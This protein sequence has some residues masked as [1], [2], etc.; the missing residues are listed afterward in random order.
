MAVALVGKRRWRGREEG[1]T[2]L[3]SLNVNIDR[4]SNFLI[5]VIM[6]RRFL[7]YTIYKRLAIPVDSQTTLFGDV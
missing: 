2:L 1:L 4:L 3:S 5:F 6:N 7:L